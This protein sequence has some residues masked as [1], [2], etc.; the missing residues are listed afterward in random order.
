MR[1]LKFRVR[2]AGSVSWHFRRSVSFL[3]SSDKDWIGMSGRDHNKKDGTFS[4]LPMDMS[5]KLVIK[6]RLA[7][8]IRRVPIHNEDITYDELILMLQRVFRDKLNNTDDV[9]LKY[10]D[11]GKP[12]S[13]WW[14]LILFN[15]HCN[16][17]TSTEGDLIT[18]VDSSDLNL[19]KQLSRLLKITI[20]GRF[21]CHVHTS[22][23]IV[24]IDYD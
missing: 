15:D 17:H 12:R 7:D 18:I 21:L 14:L 3:V 6:A 11:D 1:K 8:D 16:T 2:S 13:K 23:L 5:G 24:C 20:F 9:T 19:A 10:T 22:L 4:F